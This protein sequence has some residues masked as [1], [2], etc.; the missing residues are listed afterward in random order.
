MA[1]KEDILKWLNAQA[2]ETGLFP[3]EVDISSRKVISV[4]V[5]SLAGVSISNC[6]QLSRSISD[7]FGER[8]NGYSLD[9][10]SSGLDRPLTHPLQFVKNIGRKVSVELKN[11]K[12]LNGIL[13]SASEQELVM[14]VQPAGKKQPPQ[15]ILVLQNEIKNV[16]L[17]ISFK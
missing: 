10:S 14:T 11:G 13:Y 16:K 1:V 5:D 15:S 3:V 7:Y 17:V 8:L 6:A 4:F 9:V 2:E 12:S